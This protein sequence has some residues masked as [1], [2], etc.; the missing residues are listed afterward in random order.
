MWDLS[1][2]LQA[3]T[4]EPFEPMESCAVKLL[5]LKAFFFFVAITTARRVSE[6]EALSIRALFSSNFSRS[7]SG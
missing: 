3:L 6:L 1:L 5:T 4:G 2:V 7:D